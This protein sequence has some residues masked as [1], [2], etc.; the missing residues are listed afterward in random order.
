MHDWGAVDFRILLAPKYHGYSISAQSYEFFPH[1][2][3][4]D[5]LDLKM[6]HMQSSVLFI[7]YILTLLANFQ[8]LNIC[9]SVETLVTSS[10]QFE[11][12]TFIQKYGRISADFFF[13]KDGN[14]KALS[15]YYFF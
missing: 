8:L 2:A 6:S 7:T 3:Q 11:I 5:N 4:L 14:L 10:E 1:L 9:L 13:F 12:N 15:S